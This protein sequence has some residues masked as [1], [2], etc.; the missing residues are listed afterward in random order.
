MKANSDAAVVA[1]KDEA[2]GETKNTDSNETATAITD[3]S[4]AGDVELVEGD[5][6]KEKITTPALVQNIPQFRSFDHQIVQ[7]DNKAMSILYA[8]FVVSV[9]YAASGSRIPT[10][11]TDDALESLTSFLVFSMIGYVLICVTVMLTSKLLLFKINV[12]HEILQGNLSVAVTVAGICL[13]TS[14]N[15]R[16]SLMGNGSTDIGETVGVTVMF[17]ALGQISVVLFGFLFQIVTFYDDQEEALKGNVAA[18][19]K[20]AGNLVSLAI[21]SSSPIEKTSEL[22]SFGVFF[23]LGGVF[24]ILF[25]QLVS[26]LVVPGK[27]NEEISKD[28]NWGYALIATS[29]LL[30][31]SLAVDALLVDLP[32]PGS[33]AWDKY[34]ASFITPDPGANEG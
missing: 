23:S 5:A 29:I 10:D 27:L 21:V 24:V 12:R 2:S 20:W 16:A 1:E 31:T 30:T 8:G 19:I 7:S 4:G 25:D 13:A 14:I 33:D 18:G 34:Q 26:R 22:A 11:Y 3:N 28:Q 32:C 15:L 6:K 17:F 9:M